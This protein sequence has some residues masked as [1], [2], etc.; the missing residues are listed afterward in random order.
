MTLHIAHM[1]GIDQEYFKINFFQN[2]EHRHPIDARALNSNVG[3]PF[4][5]T[6]P[7]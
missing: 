2:V 4:T 3:Y 1:S 5:F 7:S 6:P